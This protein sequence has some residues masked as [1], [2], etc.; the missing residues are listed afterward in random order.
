M[1]AH[2]I[3]TGIAGAL[4][5]TAI[6]G[7]AQAQMR[8]YP[9]GSA[10]NALTGGALVSCQNQVY[11]QQLESGISQM[12]ADPA[13]VQSSHIEGNEAAQADFVPGAEGTEL[14][15]MPTVAPTLLYSLPGPEGVQVYGPTE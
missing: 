8:I 15:G 1:K 5:L 12:A 7:S 14:P 13:E 2:A 10:C 3:Y 6:A 9:D 11:A 4:L